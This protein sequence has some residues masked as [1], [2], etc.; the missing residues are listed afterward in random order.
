MKLHR[1]HQGLILA[2]MRRLY[3]VSE[4]KYAPCESVG[5]DSLLEPLLVIRGTAAVGWEF[6]TMY[7]QTFLHRTCA[8]H[9]KY[10]R[11]RRTE[12]FNQAGAR[13]LNVNI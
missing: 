8:R 13:G 6:C 3:M 11:R 4:I 7:Y 9:I 12:L 2:Q 5:T 1:R 10:V